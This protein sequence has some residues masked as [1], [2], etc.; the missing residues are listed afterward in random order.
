MLFAKQSSDPF[1]KLFPPVF[2]PTLKA[3]FISFKPFLPL[4][5]TKIKTARYYVFTIKTAT[6]VLTYIN[7]EE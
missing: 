2:S 7:P 4:C 1:R 3:D 5:F 6:A